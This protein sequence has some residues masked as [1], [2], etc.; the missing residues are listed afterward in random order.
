MYRCNFNTHFFLTHHTKYRGS[1]AIV[2]KIEIQNLT[3]LHVLDTEYSKN[4][5]FRKKEIV[6]H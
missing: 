2:L 5:F 3:Y 4:T 6:I 1:F